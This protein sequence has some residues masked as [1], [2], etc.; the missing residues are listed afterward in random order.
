MNSEELWENSHLFILGNCKSHYFHKHCRE[1][2]IMFFLSVH[3]FTVMSRFTSW[4]VVRSSTHI[5]LWESEI[6][7]MLY[8]AWPYLSSFHAFSHSTTL[9]T[10]PVRNLLIV[11]LINTCLSYNS[12]V[13]ICCPIDPA[14]FQL[15]KK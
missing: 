2:I 6:I 1:I 10:T 9:P 14:L 3:L 15:A 5:I 7:P 13:V 8:I 12:C 11:S 4:L